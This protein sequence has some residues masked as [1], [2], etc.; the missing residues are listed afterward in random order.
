MLLVANGDHATLRHHARR[1]RASTAAVA[2]LIAPETAPSELFAPA[3]AAAEP[4][5]LRS[6][7]RAPC[8]SAPEPVREP[9]C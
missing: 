1:H 4:P 7:R 3:L 5:V 6:A 9:G 2:H 8:D